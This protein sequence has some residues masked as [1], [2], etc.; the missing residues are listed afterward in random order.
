[1]TVSPINP[2]DRYS[3]NPNVCFE[4]GPAI[5]EQIQTEN[6]TFKHFIVQKGQATLLLLPNWTS[7]SQEHIHEPYQRCKKTKRNCVQVQHWLLCQCSTQV[8]GE[9][10]EGRGKHS[11]AAWCRLIYHCTAT[12]YNIWCSQWNTRRQLG[13]ALWRSMIHQRIP[14]KDTFIFPQSITALKWSPWHSILTSFAAG[15]LQLT[16][17]PL[18]QVL[19]LPTTPHAPLSGGIWLPLKLSRQNEEI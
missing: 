17:H 6:I 19:L 4:A 3:C 18:A 5:W 10:P 2:G 11:V 15:L 12:G 1:M 14:L 7:L 8:F 13:R 9:K 16:C